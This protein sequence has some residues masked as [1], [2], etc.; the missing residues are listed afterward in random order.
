MLKHFP[1]KG[2][3]A[4]CAKAARRASRAINQMSAAKPPGAVRRKKTR[5]IK[6]QERDPIRRNWIAL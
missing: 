5:Q 2:P 4:F 1:R 3:R 6:N